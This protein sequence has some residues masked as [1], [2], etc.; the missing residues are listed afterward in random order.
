MYTLIPQENSKHLIYEYRLRF[1][2]LLFIFLSSAVW[3]GIVSL[4]PSY[5]VSITEEGYATRQANSI[6]AS[7]ASKTSN[8]LNHEIAAINNMSGSL[9]RAQDSV[10]I[11]NIIEDFSKR[12][13][14]GVSISSFEIVR[15]GNAANPGAMSVVI[16]GQ[17]NTRETFTAFRKAL[18]AD[19]S[20]SKVD[21]PV[22]NLAQSKNINFSLTITTI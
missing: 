6:K 4:F 7:P 16:R 18:E 21:F 12:K 20:V 8:A 13:V 14:S 9:V 22:S 3:V 19:A 17:A 5:I 2:A 1:V 11:S 15:S 10:L